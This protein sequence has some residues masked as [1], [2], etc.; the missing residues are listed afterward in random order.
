MAKK[1]AAQRWGVTALRCLRSA[2][3]VA[4]GLQTPIHLHNSDVFLACVL[5]LDRL[6]PCANASLSDTNDTDF[7]FLIMVQEVSGA[8]NAHARSRHAR[9][10][11]PTTPDLPCTYLTYRTLT[12]P[13]P[14]P[15]D[16][17]TGARPGIMNLQLGQFTPCRA[18]WRALRAL[19]G[20]RSLSAY[21]GTVE[22]DHEFTSTPVV[23]LSQA[24]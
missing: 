3:A 18:F 24:R 19:A 7:C 5:R 20:R 21:L 10:N 17:S 6:E 4:Q 2:A 9:R 14:W 8:A 1:R 15:P 23:V 11:T 22:R 12:S 13:L 16:K